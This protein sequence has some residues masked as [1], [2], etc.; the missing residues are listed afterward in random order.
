MNCSPGFL[1]HLVAAFDKF[2]G[3]AT[4]AEVSGAAARAARENGWSAEELP[5]AD[6]GEGT[7]DALSRVLGGERRRAVVRGPLG[8]PVDAEWLYVPE[9]LQRLPERAL[10]FLPHGLH[11]AAGPVAVI[12]AALAAGRALLPDPRGEDPVRARTDGVGDLIL[13]AR[14]AGARLVVVGVGGSATTDGGWGAL[15]AL[16]GPRRFEGAELMVAYDVST[17]FRLAARTFGPQKGATPAQVAALTARLDE[18]A[19]RYREELGVDVDR[20]DG[21]GAA[22]GLAGGLAA[23]GARLVPGFALVADLVGL[24]RRVAAADLV[25]TG[26]GRLDATSFDGKV[27]G[28][29]LGAAGGSARALCVA[30][31]IERG[32]E[33]HWASRQGRVEPVSLVA[34]VGKARALQATTQCVFDV[35]A[36]ACRRWVPG[37]APVASSG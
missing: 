37:G 25:A 2:R 6:G 14:E 16:G 29:V 7:L 4:A 22:G 27:V 34:T 28:G 32:V 13:A 19:R 30:G 18:L 3:T 26:E 11:R 12:E 36:A 33:R 24:D 10:P 9:G 35:V 17:P 5:L 21:A 20:L 8:E 15:S 31:Q 1:P 23:V